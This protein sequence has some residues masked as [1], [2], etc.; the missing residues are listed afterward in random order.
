METIDRME[1]YDCISFGESMALFAASSPGHL[2]EVSHFTRL[3][4]GAESNVLVGLA[5]LGHRVAWI[6]RL[7]DDQLGRYVQSAVRAEGVDTRFTQLHRGERTG[8][9]FKTRSVDGQDP[10]VEYHRAGSAASAMGL[11]NISLEIL[12]QTRHLHLTG[13]LPALSE[14]CY[15]LSHAALIEARR[16]GVCTS[17]DVNLRP[18]LWRDESHM[19]E[20]I[21]ALCA[22][23]DWVMPGL[24]EA[25][26]LTGLQSPTD[27]A[28]FYLTAGARV[29]IV[30]LGEDGAFLR[31]HGGVS[32]QVPAE[33]VSQIV[34][35]VGAGDG[36]AAG[37][38][39][40]RLDGGSWEQALQCGAWIGAR[41]IQVAG[42]IEGLPTRA[43]WEARSPIHE[44]IS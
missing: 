11:D 43:E 31:T 40:A 6:S 27:V 8:L 28:N 4:A 44:Q 25:Q 2:A 12:S 33:Q 7:G 41:Q 20:R 39:S 15:A 37:V 14:S 24:S 30:K 21:N 36:F 9:M 23:A 38:I 17:F 34:D 3:L 35:T 19:R 29:V 5:R 42:D 1:M 10:K 18:S 16:L 26:Y 32:L 13:I 22:L